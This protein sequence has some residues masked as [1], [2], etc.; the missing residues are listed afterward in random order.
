M[1]QLTGRVAIITGAGRGIGASIAQRFAA[2]GASVV[3]ND[4]GTSTDGS[5]TDLGPVS[6]IADAIT[7]SGG[8]A[9]AD[10]GDI[11]DTATGERLV[12]LAVDNFGRLDAVVNVAGILR[13]KMVFNMSDQE[14]D[15]VIRVHLRGHFSTL[16]PAS[17]YWREQHNPDG[18]FRIINFTSSAG[19]EGSPGQANYGAAKLGVVGLTYALAQ[20]LARYGVTANAISPSAATRLIAGVAP[21]MNLE[22][23]PEMSPDNIATLAAYLASDKSDWLSGRVLASRGYEVALYNNPAPIA[24]VAGDAPWTIEGLAAAAEREF[25]SLADGLPPSVFVRG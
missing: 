9:V 2:E 24:K 18:H 11:A 23:N 8:A 4:L 17:A 15:S 20:G 14:W 3:L 12:K 21:G 16:R 1:T 6:E 22:D 10:G 5:G 19:L 13:D 7:A 25:R